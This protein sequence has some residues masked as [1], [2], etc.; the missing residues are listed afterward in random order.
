MG[1]GGPESLEH[2]THCQCLPLTRVE[3]ITL[4]LEAIAGRLEAIL[5]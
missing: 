3:A 1:S 2:G 4:R 5:Y